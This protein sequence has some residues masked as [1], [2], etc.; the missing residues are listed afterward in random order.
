MD[1]TTPVAPP[2]REEVAMA[3]QRLKLNEASGYDGLP[4]ELFKAGVDELRDLTFN[5]FGYH[6]NR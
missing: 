4:A 5:L 1:N 2:D 3:I 6:V